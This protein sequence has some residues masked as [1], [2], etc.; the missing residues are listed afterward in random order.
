MFHAFDLRFVS[1]LLVSL[2]Q[3]VLS[4]LSVAN[5]VI[6][7]LPGSSTTLPVLIV[8]T[9]APMS[10]AIL[11]IIILD[12]MKRSPLSALTEVILC[13]AA[14]LVDLISAVTIVFFNMG[15][16]ICKARSSFAFWNACGAHFAVIAL[17]WTA[18]FLPYVVKRYSRLHPLDQDSVWKKKVKQIP[19]DRASYA[20]KDAP[21]RRLRKQGPLD[22]ES[23]RRV[24]ADKESQ[25]LSR[26]VGYVPSSPLPATPSRSIGRPAGL[27]SPV[28]FAERMG[29]FRRDVQG[30]YVPST[31][32]LRRELPQGSLHHIPRQGVERGAIVRMQTPGITDARRPSFPVLPNPFPPKY[33]FHGAGP[34]AQGPVDSAPRLWPSSH[35]STNSSDSSAG[36]AGL[37]AGPEPQKDTLRASIPVPLELPHYRGDNSPS[38]GPTQ[39]PRNSVFFSGQQRAFRISAPLIPGSAPSPTLPGRSP[40]PV[41]PPT[42]PTSLRPGQPTGAQSGF[43]YPRKYSLPQSS[44]AMTVST[45]PAPAVAHRPA[46]LSSPQTRPRTGSASTS[47]TLTRPA[48][49]Q[50]T[51]TT[52]PPA[53]LSPSTKQRVSNLAYP[54]PLPPLSTYPIK[55]VAASARPSTQGHLKVDLSSSI[56][57]ST[58][59]G[60]P[61]MKDRPLSTISTVSCYSTSS[62]SHGPQPVREYILSLTSPTRT[63]E[64]ATDKLPQ[65]SDST[66]SRRS[67]KSKK[68]STVTRSTSR[69]GPTPQT[70]WGGTGNGPARPSLAYQFQRP[71]VRQNVQ[72]DTGQIGPKEPNSQMLEWPRTDGDASNRPTG[73]SFTKNEDSQGNVNYYRF[74]RDTEE[75]SVAWRR[76]IGTYVAEAMGLPGGKVYWMKGWPEGYAFYDHQKGQL[77]NP[78]HDLYLCGSV[79]ASR[80]RSKNEFKPHAKWLMTDPT[81]N[82]QNCGCKYCT[83]TKSQV[84]VNQN[85]GLRGLQ[86]PPEHH[87]RGTKPT[88]GEVMTHARRRV[89]REQQKVKSEKPK[90]TPKQEQALTALPERLRDINSGRA[91]RTYEL[92]W[93]TLANPIPITEDGLLEIEF[94]PAII[95]TYSTKN[96]PTPHK[97]GETDYEIVAHFT[98]NV[99]LLGV[100]HQVTVSG[101]RLLPQLGYIPSQS[102]LMTV[103]ECQPNRPPVSREFSEYARFNPLPEYNDVLELPH[104]NYTRED[105]LPAF[106]L[107]LHVVA[108]LTPVWS[109]TNAYSSDDKGV[110]EDELF[111]GLWW[112]SERIWLDDVVRL[113][114]PREELDPENTL[115]LLPPSSPDA[116]DRA[117]FLRL[118][119]IVVDREDPTG[120][121]ICVGGDLYELARKGTQPL[122][123][124]PRLSIFGPP[125]GLLGPPS[126]NTVDMFAA[127]SSSPTLNATVG[128]SLAK[129]SIVMPPP[130]PG[131]TFRRLLAP[132]NEMVLDIGAVA[133]R[134]YPKVLQEETL[135]R[136]MQ[137]VREEKGVKAGEAASGTV[138]GYARERIRRSRAG[139]QAFETAKDALI[140]LVTLMGLY[141]GEGNSMHPEQWAKGRLQTIKGAE[142]NAR[143][144]LFERW[145]STDEAGDVEMRDA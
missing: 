96:E 1:L 124:P 130:P 118:T 59:G 32:T 78:R 17:L 123:S 92:V 10:M 63:E 136:V 109:A 37:G 105:I 49:L 46:S 34:P 144:V 87:L 11:V 75:A 33:T 13:A 8:A 64:V 98:F 137:T 54:L 117:L 20:P 83:K 66:L 62:A 22:I 140:P 18:T 21:G 101:D 94:W 126:S 134:Y 45:T 106:T 115:G 120:M 86:R 116:V 90:A 129:S 24:V 142:L 145:T 51:L 135:N 31:P 12:H 9:N 121:N 122:Q 141:V 128:P 84:E 6:A 48:F 81:L 40:Q 7:N 139:P 133:G 28:G 3:G 36:F 104:G 27:D 4:L 65:R 102:L 80:F 127:G 108:C 72:N 107:A 99:R 68:P 47:T 39:G 97:P 91:F 69:H 77:P 55:S 25:T 50:P 111:Q 60:V 103:K 16:A 76:E 44:L 125:T 114:P 43:G 61:A 112:G 100:N 70:L 26:Q 53:T 14:G 73:I 131:F 19:W 71:Q 138:E 113:R 89:V 93:V 38:T 143:N 110:S 85:Q 88:P 57:E 52:L 42:L 29:Y 23:L 67:S 95:L 41:Q 119:Y 5:I 30:E 58:Q 132:G 35:S 82:T 15:D 56:D 74:V 2:C 79:V